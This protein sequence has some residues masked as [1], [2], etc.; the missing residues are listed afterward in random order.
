[1]SNVGDK[2]D[3]PTC[4]KFVQVTELIPNEDREGWYIQKLSCGH[5]DNIRIMDPLE[6]TVTIED[7][8]KLT[9][10]DS[11][12]GQVYSEKTRKDSS[13]LCKNKNCGHPGTQHKFLVGYNEGNHNCYLCD[14]PNY[15]Q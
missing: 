12:Y 10:I 6:E 4:H 11:K 9:K 5:T 8:V 1:M 2:Q 7:K 14:C 3:C 13:I 15:I